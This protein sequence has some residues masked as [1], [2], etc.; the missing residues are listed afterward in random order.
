MILSVS[1]RTDIPCRFTPWFLNRLR[2]G[3]ALVRNP[4]RPSQVSDL[5]SAKFILITCVSGVSQSSW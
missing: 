5:P 2:A 4:L 3:Y 1:R